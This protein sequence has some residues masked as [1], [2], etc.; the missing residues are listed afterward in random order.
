MFITLKDKHIHK[1]SHF[2]SSN[3]VNLFIFMAI[4]FHVFMPSTSNF[5][6]V[7]GNF[8]EVKGTYWFGPVRVSAHN[9]LDTVKN[10]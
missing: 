6:E 8:E 3:T 9:A 1:T 5:K 4:N 7:E 2:L 10:G